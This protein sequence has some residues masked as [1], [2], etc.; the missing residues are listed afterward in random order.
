MSARAERF[1][2]VRSIVDRRHG[3]KISVSPMTSG[4]RLSS[5]SLD[6]A[7][8]PF[9]V[10]GKVLVAAGDQVGYSDRSNT[11]VPAGQAEAYIDAQAWP[12]AAS[13]KQGDELAAEE[14][15][16]L[17]FEVERLDRREMG[18]LVF[19]LNVRKDCA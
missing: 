6:P 18:R 19:R 7:R 3:D 4:G 15:E 12:K 8:E 2:R 13:I 1:A 5:K 10:V 9:D 16:G 17:T 11:Q 14:H